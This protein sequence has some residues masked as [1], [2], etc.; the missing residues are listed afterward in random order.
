MSETKFIYFF[1]DGK[2]EGDA[3]K[4]QLLGGKGA[5][6]AEMTNLGIPVPPGFTISTEVCDAF[7][8]N[9]RQ[10]PEGLDAELKSTL[11]KLEKLMGKKLGDPKDPL[12]VSVRSGAAVSMPGMMDT[13][14]NL[15]M[16]DAAVEGLSA[17]TGNPRFAWDAYR[18]F[19]QMFSNVAL[20]MDIN[21]FEDILEDM[22]EKKGVENDNEL[23]AEDLQELVTLYKVAFKGN[24]NEDFP[25]DPVAQLQAA[26][27]AVFGSWNNPKAIKYREINGI[28][29]LKGT[30]VNV[31][32][33]V[34]GNFGDDYGTGVCCSR[35]PSTGENYFYGE[36]L[37]NAQGEDVVAGIRTPEKL[38]KL[39]KQDEN[40]YGQ[41]VAI[42][43][44]LET[45]YRDMQDMEFTIQQGTLYILQTRNGKRTGAS[46]VKVAVDMAKAGLIT[47]EEAMFRVEAEQLDKLFH[48][49][50]DPKVKKTLKPLAKGLNA[51]PGAATGKI[52]FT[53]EDA[54]LWVERGDTKVMLV[55]KETSPDDIGG[56]HV[57]QGILTSTGGMTSHAAVVARG[58]GRPC[59]AG[60]KDIVISGKTMKVQGKEFKEGEWITIDGTTG[61]VF[62]GQVETIPPE[63]SDELTDFLAWADDIRLADERKGLAQ[64]GFLV[65]TNADQPED[66]KLARSLGAEG[67]GLCRTEHMFFDAGKLEHFQEMI[68]A[69]TTEGRKKALSSILNLQKADFKGIFKAMSGLPVTV[70]LLD[71]P[72]HEFV[73][74]TDE[75]I[76]KIAAMAGITAEALEEKIEALHEHNPML[77]HRGCRLG[78]TY[79]EIYDMQVEAIISAAVEVEAEGEKVLPEIMIPLV[80]SWQE[81]KIL[82]DNAEAVIEKVFEKTNKRVEYKIGTMIEIPRAALT[83][84]EVAEHADFFSFGTNDLTQ[85]TYGFSRDDA[86]AFLPSYISQGILEKDPTASLDQTGVGKLVSMAADLGRGIKADLKLGICGEHGGDPASIDFCYRTNLN[87][88]SCSPF[89]VPIARHAAA[90]AVLRNK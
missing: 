13:I 86:G 67:I 43:D 18:R 28:K 51:S 75:D 19:I 3:S 62:K 85:M 40:I 80:G 68:V 59:V 88:V 6:L 17:I 27:D 46:G 9:D 12:L 65:R 25:Q 53:A 44:K 50:I 7:Y 64:K 47:K 10:Y 24:Q 61:E 45:H 63:M 22:R 1:G 90:Q 41:L 42:K 33:M 20:G 30:A 36:Y 35:D 73:P 89:R 69:D 56:M 34:F 83:A 48:P 60:C 79:P 70:R 54:E 57:A 2:A 11:A 37:M 76:K 49:M 71:P 26:I 14:L 72:L 23:S 38:S 39:A 15:G 31:Q 21:V 84:D 78:V 8:K 74:Q 87:Y 5:N 82:R 29:A 32:S 58:M 77:G 55:R 81:L 4:K 66:A 16:N 52:V